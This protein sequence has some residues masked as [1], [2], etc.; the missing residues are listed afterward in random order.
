VIAEEL[1]TGTIKPAGRID[2]LNVNEDHS[3]QEMTRSRWYSDE[4][5]THMPLS[6]RL[7]SMTTNELP[8]RILLRCKEDQIWSLRSVCDCYIYSSDRHSATMKEHK[9]GAIETALE[10][11]YWY[12]ESN[13]GREL[14]DS[15]VPFNMAKLSYL[16]SAETEREWY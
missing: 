15:K 9:V 12:L 11:A 10:K 1:E 3:R 14:K 6:K 8:F 7:G 4:E 5:K 13:D 16:P 2:E